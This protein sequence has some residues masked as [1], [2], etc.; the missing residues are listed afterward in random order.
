MI[1]VTFP[2][3]CL[4]LMSQLGIQESQVVT[5]INERH[6]G[7]TD[8]GVTRVVAIRW[9][10]EQQ[11]VMVESIITERQLEGTRV[12]IDKVAAQLAIL[13]RPT[14]PGGRIHRGM[15]MIDI[16]VMVAASFGHPLSCHPDE[17]SATLYAGAWDGRQPN[18]KINGP[19]ESPVFVIG[20]LDPVQG[21]AKM[22]WAFDLHR[23]LQW[24]S[25]Q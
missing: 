2:P 19:P 8:E 21:T 9:F 25:I 17:P 11:I 20:S 4:Q 13:L 12:R 16:L 22:V 23:Y 5:T 7:L 3:E 1:A 10:D 14:L 24:L 6:Q 15:E 18:I